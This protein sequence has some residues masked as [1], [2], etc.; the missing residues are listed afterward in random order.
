[1]PIA[2]CLNKRISVLLEA[3]HVLLAQWVAQPLFAEHGV[4]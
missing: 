2:V 4:A 3:T 1:M